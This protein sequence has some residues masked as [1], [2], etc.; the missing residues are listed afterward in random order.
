MLSKTACGY[1]MA[2]MLQLLLLATSVLPVPGQPGHLHSAAPVPC[3]FRA[4][5]CCCCQWNTLDSMNFLLP[6]RV[7]CCYKLANASAAHSAAT[8]VTHT[9]EVSVGYSKFLWLW[10][11]ILQLCCGLHIRET[12]QHFKTPVGSCNRL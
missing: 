1:H 10:S 7:A 3:S 11:S 9:A 4:T 8:L 6:H 2:C 5:S 12:S